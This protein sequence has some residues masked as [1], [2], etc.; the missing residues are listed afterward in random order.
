MSAYF[1]GYTLGQIPWGYAADK[2]GI[3]R[4]MTVSLFGI[5]ISTA[6]FGIAADYWQ[7]IVARFFAGLL[8]AGLFIPA[9]KLASMWFSP[10]ERGMAL[11]IL[12]IGGSLGLVI[13]SYISP[14]LALSFGWRGS[15]MLLGLLGASSSVI[16]LLSLRD[17]NL[18]SKSMNNHNLTE[19]VRDKSFWIL[20]FL[21]FIRLGAYYT[22]IAWLPIF[23]Q[24]E[25]G[26]G[27]IAAG[28]VFSLFSWAGLLSNPLGGFVSD[29]RGEKP[30][31]FLSF[32]ILAI[33]IMVFAGLKTTLVLYIGIFTL[34][35]FINFVRSPIF[36]IIPKL[37]GSDTAGRVSG[38]QN[39]LASMGALALPF[40]LGLIRDLTASY[41]LGWGML[42]L[43]LTFGTL[44]NLFIKN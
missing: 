1:F 17:R 2:F 37:W 29:R 6:L 28:T 39:T 12:N 40:L 13:A 3:R 24:E 10:G 38:I 27:L 31:L 14:F 41:Y 11:G 19:I 16:L 20:G 5:A 21:Q 25:Y 9:V 26:L 32:L 35:W 22:F 18:I 30:V 42:A 15:M 44:V 8:G 4:V 7:V 43:L 34:G 23:M 36:T 33:A